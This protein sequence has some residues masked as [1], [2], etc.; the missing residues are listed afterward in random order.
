MYVYIRTSWLGCEKLVPTTVPV[1]NSV[2]PHR[3]STR[4]RAGPERCAFAA[5]AFV[6]RD[7]F[8]FSKGV[9]RRRLL[10]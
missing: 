9:S 5:K 10:R 2:A 1:Q 8:L 7:S 3:W 6:G 4:P